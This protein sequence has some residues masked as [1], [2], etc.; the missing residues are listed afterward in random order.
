MPRRSPQPPL[1][2]PKPRRPGPR[3]AVQWQAPATSGY[4]DRYSSF[5]P[6]FWLESF[7]SCSVLSSTAS[8]PF[9]YAPELLVSIGDR[10]DFCNYFLISG[11]SLASSGLAAS[12]GAIVAICL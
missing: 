12:S 3:P 1:H 11:H 5:S 6:L 4:D 9:E 8:A 10:P 7:L 2:P